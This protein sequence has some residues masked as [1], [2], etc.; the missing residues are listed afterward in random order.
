MRPVFVPEES[1]VLPVSACADF[2]PI[3]ALGLREAGRR[4]FRLTAEAIQTAERIVT[5][6]EKVRNVAGVVRDLATVDDSGAAEFECM[7]V[8]QAKQVLGVSGSAVTARLRLGTLHGTHRR[9][10]DPWLVCVE[11]LHARMKGSRCPH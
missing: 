9:K 7:T 5:I 1:L 3:V 4:G 11:D 2:G 6:G 8:E 10:G